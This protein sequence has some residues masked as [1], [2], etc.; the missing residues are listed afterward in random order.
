MSRDTKKALKIRAFY[1]FES[2]T[3]E[4]T[5]TPNLLIRSQTLYPIELRVLCA[6]RGAGGKRGFV[7]GVK[8]FGVIR[9]ICRGCGFLVEDREVNE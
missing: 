6:W 5:R 4:G 3:P 9:A 1:C 7:G 2:G 8:N